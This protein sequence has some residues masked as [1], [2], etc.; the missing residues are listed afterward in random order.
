[1]TVQFTCLLESQNDP[2]SLSEHFSLLLNFIINSPL[3][4]HSYLPD[5]DISVL[6]PDPGTAVDRY[7]T[8]TT[9]ETVPPFLLKGWALSVIDL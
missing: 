2:E 8:S 1:M 3:H 5:I 6:V 9:E 4:C 7:L